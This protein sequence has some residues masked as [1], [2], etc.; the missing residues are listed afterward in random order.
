M[1]PA[2]FEL[3]LARLARAVERAASEAPSEARQTALEALAY[4]AGDLAAHFEAEERALPPASPRRAQHARLRG[5]LAEIDERARTAGDWPE[6]WRSVAVAFT[7]FAAALAQHEQ[8]ER[9]R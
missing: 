3:R 2:A 1:D 9:T 6:S 4:F 8:S 5:D 7:R